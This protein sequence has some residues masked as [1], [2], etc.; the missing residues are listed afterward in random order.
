MEIIV[1]QDFDVIQTTFDHR[2]RAWLAM[3]FQQLFLKATSVHTNTDGTVIVFSGLNDFFDPLFVANVA[4]VN[5]KACSPRLSGL[6]PSFVVEMDI[7]Y[8]RHRAFATNFLHRRSAF[9]VRH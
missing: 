3:F 4:W 7:G 9:R 2:I 8:D 6:N 1:L 5:P